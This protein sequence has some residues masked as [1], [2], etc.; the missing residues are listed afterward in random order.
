MMIVS[1]YL[2]PLCVRHGAS[3]MHHLALQIA[4]LVLVQHLGQAPDGHHDA[5]RLAGQRALVTQDSGLLLGGDHQ[6]E[7]LRPGHK[8]L[9]QD[10]EI[11]QTINIHFSQVT[12]G[13][14]SLFVCKY[15]RVK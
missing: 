3:A 14:K 7:L 4:S 8:V 10:P 12:N 9:H 1:S 15:L 13:L 5:V 2:I 11:I 6:P